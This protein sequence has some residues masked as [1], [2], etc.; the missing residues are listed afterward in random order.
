MSASNPGS[1][2][3]AFSFS[4]IPN[5]RHDPTKPDDKQDELHEDEM[6]SPIAIMAYDFLTQPESSKYAFWWNAFT[7][8]LV[9]IRIIEIGVE[10]V[11][12]PNQYHN[13]KV[14]RSRYNFLFTDE[15]YFHVYIMC[16]VPL[17]IDGF[18]RVV[19][20]VLMMCE[21]ENKGLYIKFK[22]NMTERILFVSDTFGL[23]PFFIYAGYVRPNDVSLSQAARITL[24][25]MELFTTGRIFR[26]VRRFPAI[27]AISVALGN[28]FE[29][30]VLPIFFFFVFNITAG[31][32][33][34]FV[35]P[36]YDASLCPWIN[37]FES[38]FYA[39]VTMTTSKSFCIL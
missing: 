36:C 11:N 21:R 18:A 33:F 30:L 10:S 17:I 32:F 3:K 25:L 26:A 13:R 15:E 31:V 34:Y 35:E 4:L 22:K 20:M 39:I 16:F 5:E 9:V 24:R 37:L 38:T 8:F 12:G 19:L 23:L 1:L 7:S 2:L 27:R 6:G 29:H 14:N 28:A